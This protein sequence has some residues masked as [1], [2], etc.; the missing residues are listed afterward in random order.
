[1]KVTIAL[2]IAA[3]ILYSCKKE[4]TTTPI[5]NNN[6]GNTSTPTACDSTIA[7]GLELNNS[8]LDASCNAK[9]ANGINTTFTTDRNN[10]ASKAVSFNGSTSYI[11]LPNETTLHPAFPFSVSFWVN[12]SD[13]AATSN[14]FVQSQIASLYYGFWIH[15]VGGTGQLAANIGDGSGTSSGNR[16]SGVSSARLSTNRWTHVTVVFNTVNNF[17]M[18]FNG[19]ADN[20]VA[21]SGTATS[22]AYLPTTTTTAKGRV[23]G[24]SGVTTTYYNGKLDKVKIWSRALTSTEVSTEYNLTN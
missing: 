3:S 6:S 21:Y 18:Y 19:V 9:N 1:M 17:Q 14:H 2:V 13:S 24:Y 23:G 5:S 22:I 7:F 4:T 20:A 11:E 10:N 15:G 8:Y 12:P 16:N